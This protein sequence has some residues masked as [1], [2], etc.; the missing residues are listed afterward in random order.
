LQVTWLKFALTLVIWIAGILT[1]SL[2]LNFPGDCGP[3]VTNCGEGLRRVSFV[4]LAFG[5]IGLGYYTYL[6]LSRRRGH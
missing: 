2:M 3:E 5:T 1:L 6:F 4:V